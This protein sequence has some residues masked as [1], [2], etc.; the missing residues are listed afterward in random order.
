MGLRFQ[1]TVEVDVDLT[2]PLT[3]QE[4]ARL[5]DRVGADEVLAL[6]APDVELTP[7]QVRDVVWAKLTTRFPEVMP[8]QFD[9]VFE[10]VGVA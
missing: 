6:V 8:D 9:S 1:V 10:E 3:V 4:L 5:Q 2:E 7:V